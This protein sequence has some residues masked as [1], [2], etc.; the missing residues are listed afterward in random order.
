M[1]GSATYSITATASDAV[2]AVRIDKQLFHRVA[3]EYPEF[4][5]AVLNALSEKLGA[6]VRELDTVRSLLTKS[7]SFS[8]L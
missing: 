4:G 3:T 5:R 2:S 6:S 7:K 8:N 1:L